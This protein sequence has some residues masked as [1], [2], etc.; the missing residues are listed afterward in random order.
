MKN[1]LEIFNYR[2]V[3]S[4]AVTYLFGDLISSAGITYLSNSDSN[5]GNTPSTSP[6]F[7]VPLESLTLSGVPNGPKFAYA[8][9]G[10]IA[11]SPSGG[12][13][14]LVSLTLPTGLW[15]VEAKAKNIGVSIGGFGSV[16]VMYPVVLVDVDEG[17]Y[18]GIVFSPPATVSG[19]TL[20]TIQGPGYSPEVSIKATP[21]ITV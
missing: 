7:W 18:E 21:I 11:L 13:V 5:T 12:S 3:Y 2:G 15:F 4:A 1:I 10:P 8:A 17:K 16:Q 6:S 20:N 19:I 14:Q 9:S